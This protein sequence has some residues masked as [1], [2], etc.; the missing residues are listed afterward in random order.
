MYN[1]LNMNIKGTD[2]K[3]IEKL[4]SEKAVNADVAAKFIEKN[5]LVGELNEM[6]MPA[7]VSRIESLIEYFI[8]IDS[9][10]AL[11][12]FEMGMF[13]AGYSYDVEF[14][15]YIFDEDLD[16]EDLEE[17]LALLS[18]INYSSPDTEMYIKMTAAENSEG[19][20]IKLSLEI[21]GVQIEMEIYVVD[22][23]I[24]INAESPEL[25]ETLLFASLDEEEIEEA[26]EMFEK[27]G[28][29]GTEMK[30]KIEMPEELLALG[31][32]LL[33]ML[34]GYDI[35]EIID[36]LI[37]EMKNEIL[38]TKIPA[39]D[40]NKIEKAVSDKGVTFIIVPADVDEGSEISMT[41]D[42]EGNLVSM[43]GNVIEDWG[44]SRTEA[45]FNFVFQD[46]DIYVEYFTKEFWDE[47]LESETRVII[48]IEEDT[49]YMEI[50]FI[51]YNDGEADTKIYFVMDISMLDELEIEFPDFSDY[52]DLDMDGLFEMLGIDL[53]ELY[54]VL[55]LVTG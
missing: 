46:D 32:E 52:M 12:E 34:G 39:Y 40:I 28:I 49:I 6:L 37:D 47:D 8:N 11:V 36:S 23:C 48:K 27:L 22:N 16:E 51:E 2:T 53:S 31:E 26:M 9:E 5:K 45:Q 38:N 4:V 17:L 44:Y 24:Y 33:S 55:E 7:V 18:E 19:S 3:L 29:S 30:L 41:F 10:A 54:N 50:Y 1:A 21:M 13:E 42:S 14:E 15:D 20:A 43:V 35:N 25:F